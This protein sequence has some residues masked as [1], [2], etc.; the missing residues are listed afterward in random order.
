MRCAV[1]I[2]RRKYSA[3]DAVRALMSARAGPMYWCDSISE[4]R[5]SATVQIVLQ[6]SLFSCPFRR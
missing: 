2:G 1:L 4:K 3:D 6:C 5:S